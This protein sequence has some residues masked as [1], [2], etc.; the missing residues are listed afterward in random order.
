[1]RRI[2]TMLGV[3]ALAALPITA[4]LTPEA[5]A[6]PSSYVLYKSYGWPDAC[7]SAGYAG[8]QAHQWTSYYC[9]TVYP[10]S[11]NGPGLY[12]LYVAY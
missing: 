9:T 12:D 11:P 7:S 2:A 5:H 3:A 6:S 8:E 1:M 10:A 4:G